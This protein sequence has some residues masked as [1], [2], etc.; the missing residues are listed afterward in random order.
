MIED[1]KSD[2]KVEA[3][4]ASRRF[5]DNIEKISKSTHP[6]ILSVVIAALIIDSAKRK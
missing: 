5:W 1:D 4:A 2:A 6:D 3:L